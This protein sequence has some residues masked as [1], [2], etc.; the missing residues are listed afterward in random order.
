MDWGQLK[1]GNYWIYQRY[2]TDT[3]GVET[4]LGIFDSCY[5]AGDTVIT[6]ITYYKMV[7]PTYGSPGPQISY[8]RESGQYL[9]NHLGRILFATDEFGT[10]FQEGYITSGPDTIAHQTEYMT[11]EGLTVGT[12]AG[13][14]TTK[15]F[16]QHYDVSPTWVVHYSQFDQYARYAEGVGIVRETLPFFLSSP[17]IID[18]RL[19]SYHLEP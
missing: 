13:M 4:P 19:V 16:V 15:S 3:A 12:P 18:R 2:R 9:V 14:F 17:F 1:V 8:L 7:R 5:V 10:I 6:G 11:D